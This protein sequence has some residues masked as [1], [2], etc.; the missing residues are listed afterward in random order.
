MNGQPGTTADPAQAAGGAAIAATAD[1]SVPAEYQA[2]VD[3]LLAG[4]GRW[5]ILV[6]NAAGGLRTGP[7]GPGRSRSR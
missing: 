1:V 3:H 5:D 4:F 2:M 6:N 7:A